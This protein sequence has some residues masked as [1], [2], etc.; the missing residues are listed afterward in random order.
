M[1]L[2]IT[3]IADIL[4]LYMNSKLKTS[5]HLPYEQAEQP[6]K[7]MSW[8]NDVKDISCRLLTEHD[9][10]K[11][12]NIRLAGLNQFSD[13]FGTTYAEEFKSKSNGF[14]WITPQKSSILHSVRLPVIKN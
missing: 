6:L 1:N 5:F 4:V 9:Y 10:T 12:K 14:I 13:Y 2:L 3:M 8:L 11:Y 7:S